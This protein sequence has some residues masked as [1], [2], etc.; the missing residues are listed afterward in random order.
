MEERKKC[1]WFRKKEAKKIIINDQTIRRRY[2]FFGK[3]QGVGFRFYAK[4]HADSLGLSGWVQNEEDGSV[5]M[6]VQGQKERIEQMIVLI[7]KERSIE[8]DAYN[9]KVIPIDPNENQFTYYY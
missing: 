2:R 4:M 5:L 1:M 3:V 6:E 9:Y 7:K 8:V